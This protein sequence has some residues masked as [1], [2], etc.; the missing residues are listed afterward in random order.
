MTGDSRRLST[1][2][3]FTSHPGF[4]MSWGLVGSP[5]D[6]KRSNRCF[7]YHF[8]QITMCMCVEVCGRSLLQMKYMVTVWCISGR[9]TKYSDELWSHPVTYGPC[10]LCHSRP[11]QIF[12]KTLERRSHDF[13]STH[14][15]RNITRYSALSNQYS[16]DKYNAFFY[17]NW[18]EY[19]GNL[20]KNLSSNRVFFS[21]LFSHH[22]DSWMMITSKRERFRTFAIG[23]RKDF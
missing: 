18:S 2:S 4:W 1:K 21:A 8:G 12:V 19:S 6:F 23:K 7:P 14:F 22:H 3:P 11:E 13:L 10:A 9:S 15:H 17:G 20:K 5:Y 16:V